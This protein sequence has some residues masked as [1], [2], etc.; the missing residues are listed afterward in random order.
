MAEFLSN[1]CMK[2]PLNR[3]SLKFRDDITFRIYYLMTHDVKSILQWAESNPKQ[4][5]Y[6]QRYI[7]RI[8]HWIK[9]DK[10]VKKPIFFRTR[11]GKYYVSGGLESPLRTY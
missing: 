11:K 6:S 1:E 9:K 10:V 5:A 2:I 4:K 8:F 7:D 3:I